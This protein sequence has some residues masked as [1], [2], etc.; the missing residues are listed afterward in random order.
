MAATDWQFY[1]VIAG[2]V[3]TGVFFWLW[4]PA[5]YADSIASDPWRLVSFLLIYPLLEEWVFRGV[6]QGELLKREWGKRRGIGISN[7]NL[8][9]SV[10]FVLLHFIN[11]PPLWAVAVFVPSLVFGHFRERHESLVTPMLLHSFFNL[12]YLL[13]G[14]TIR[15]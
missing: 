3:A 10:V 8:V 15:A 11:H 12:T 4:L 5:G 6:L 9:T 1:L 14:I 7:A 2:S 13:A